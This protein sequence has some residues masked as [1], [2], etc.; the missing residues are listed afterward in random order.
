MEK[1]P[2][3]MT[4][5]INGLKT[6]STLSGVL[7]SSN[8]SDGI[9]RFPEVARTLPVPVH[10]Q[11]LE[12]QTSTRRHRL[13]RSKGNDGYS[14]QFPDP[15]Q[16]R[17]HKSRGIGQKRHRTVSPSTR[18]PSHPKHIPTRSTST[19]WRRRQASVRRHIRSRP[20]SGCW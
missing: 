7:N 13:P 4:I 11:L 1:Q 3:P 12:P 8:C 15:L 17:P 10:S 19:S 18:I 2:A 5:A 16:R 20:M 6:P 9:A 14:S